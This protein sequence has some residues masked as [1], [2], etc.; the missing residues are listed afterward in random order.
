MSKLP[1]FEWFVSRGDVL[2]SV[3]TSVSGVDIPSHFMKQEVVDFILGAMPT[4]KMSVNE[5]GI[6]ASMRFSGSVRQ[7]HFPWDSIVQMSGHD[8]VI[9]FRNT[10]L[11]P[12]AADEN[13]RKQ[14]SR[15]KEKPNLRL[16]K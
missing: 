4:P 3:N 10:H 2:I 5:D 6:D 9:Q 15:A 13:G 14:A 12:P 16:I 7:C 8:A 1:V 11:A